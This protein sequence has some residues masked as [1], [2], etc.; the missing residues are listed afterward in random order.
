MWRVA[1]D[2]LAYPEESATQAIPFLDPLNTKLAEGFDPNPF[3]GIEFF[4]DDSV[5]LTLTLT[6]LFAS[7]DDCVAQ[8]V[9]NIQHYS[10]STLFSHCKQCV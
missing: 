5:S 4:S 6:H 8:L 1:F 3:N 10:A 7:L 2:A 9:I